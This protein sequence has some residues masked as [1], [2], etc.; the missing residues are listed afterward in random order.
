MTS[1]KHVDILRQG[2]GLRSH[3]TKQSSARLL[4]RRAARRAVA[5]GAVGEVT[6][7]LLTPL[8][9]FCCTQPTFVQYFYQRSGEKREVLIRF[10]AR[11]PVP[12]TVLQTELTYFVLEHLAL[13]L[14]AR[15]RD[16]LPCHAFAAC[17]PG[18]RGSGGAAGPGAEQQW[19]TCGHLT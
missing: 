17:I 16:H 13:Q 8:A 15:T 11:T 19:G 5:A 7:A 12:E 1:V 10:A 2:V 18:G 9:S 14:N 3:S 6:A 4:G